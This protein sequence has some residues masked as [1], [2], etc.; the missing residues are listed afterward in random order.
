M[1]FQSVLCD[2]GT[3]KAFDQTLYYIL[4]AVLSIGVLVGIYLMSK[5]KLSV[6]GNRFSAVCMLLAIVLTLIYND[7]LPVWVLYIALAAGGCDRL[8]TFRTRENDTDASDGSF[9]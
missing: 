1:L 6:I 3:G 8:Y 7:I 2:V 5:V 9:A 4:C